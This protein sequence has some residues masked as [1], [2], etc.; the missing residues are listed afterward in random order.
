MRRAIVIWRFGCRSAHNS[1]K[2]DRRCVARAPLSTAAKAI[3][4][5]PR[6]VKAYYRRALSQLAILNTKPAIADLKHVL[7]LEPS[8][9]AA[10]DQLAATQKLMRKIEF[11]K[12]I[13]VGDTESASA[14]CRRLISDHACPVDK[15]YTGPLP[16]A[17]VDETGSWTPTVEFVEGMVEW[18]KQ[19]KTLPRRLVWEIVLGCSALL[20]AEPSLVDVTV[21]EGCTVDVIGDT[22][23]AS[24][25]VPPAVLPTADLSS[26]PASFAALQVNST[27][28]CICSA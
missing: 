26:P 24:L 25:P 19:G 14:R 22:H 11:E 18:F 4:L 15:D 17:P 28:C 2:T 21:E 1:A 12:A 3:E 20:R 9:V 6:A 8:N 16:T 23:G 27:T 13:S 10:R 7:S 5:D